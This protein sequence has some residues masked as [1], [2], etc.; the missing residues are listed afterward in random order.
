MGAPP[1]QEAAAAELSELVSSLRGSGRDDAAYCAAHAGTFLLADRAP[2]DVTRFSN[3]YRPQRPRRAEAPIDEEAWFK[4]LAHPDDDPFVAK[5]FECVLGAVRSVRSVPLA[6][7]GLHAHD[8]AHPS[9]SSIAVVRAL[10]AA[11][12][13]L[14]APMPL[15]F[16]VPE[17]SSA[18]EVL[19]TD[20]IASIAG[21]KVTAGRSLEELAFLAGHHMARYRPSQYVRVLYKDSIPELTSLF[22]ASLRAG[23][24]Q[25]AVD[26]SI[27]KVGDQ[28]RKLMEPAAVARLERVVA[29]FLERGP[30]IDIARWL[31]GAERTSLRA[32]LLLAGDVASAKS[33]LSLIESAPDGAL[34]DIVTFAMSEQYWA[35]RQR[36][37]I[38]LWPDS[39]VPTK[40]PEHV[41]ASPS[42]FP[43]PQEIDEAIARAEA[44][45]AAQPSEAAVD[46]APSDAATTSADALEREPAAAAENADAAEP[47]LFSK[48]SIP[49]G[50]VAADLSSEE[51]AAATAAAS[52]AEAASAVDRPTVSAPQPSVGE[53]ID[54]IVAALSALE[55][56]LEKTEIAQWIATLVSALRSAYARTPS[57]YDA[58]D[59][60]NQDEPDTFASA[61]VDACRWLSIAPPIV[62]PFEGLG[63]L[64]SSPPSTPALVL[65]DPERDRALAPDARRWLAAECA[66]QFVSMRVA[67]RVAPTPMLLADA[68]CAVASALAQGDEGDSE[69]SSAHAVVRHVLA[70]SGLRSSLEPLARRL[71]A[72]VFRGAVA[73]WVHSAERGA[74]RCALAL[75]DRDG[76]EDEVFAA[77]PFRPGFLGPD[78]WRAVVAEARASEHVLSARDARGVR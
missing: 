29:L 13:A 56:P 31:E 66:A 22:A 3:E 25:L 58:R 53:R 43:P 37:G 52:D 35:L 5:V 60:A 54:V 11:A 14:D 24:P 19:P 33:A 1:S 17:R 38:A 36:L 51:R 76:C 67:M 28:L 18:I 27:A 59:D 40:E 63:V 46:T 10:G 55:D 42:V 21:A 78:E 44:Q 30:K 57:D 48:P 75:C 2:D 77:R 73:R 74:V 69:G 41:R 45:E 64:W 26:P 71:S 39:P 62:A 6:K 68:V 7:V 20:P 47:S 15:A 32:G 8:A 65:V 9:R 34:S 23:R 16:V 4:L 50:L 72:E 70:D 61:L 49:T 12:F